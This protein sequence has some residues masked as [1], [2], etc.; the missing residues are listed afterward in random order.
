VP[1]PGTRRIRWIEQNAAAVT[2]ELDADDYA[3]LDPMLDH[4]VGARY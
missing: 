1:I 3:I 4:V 2:L